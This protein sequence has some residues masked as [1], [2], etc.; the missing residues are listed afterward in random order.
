L[1]SVSTIVGHDGAITGRVAVLRDITALKELDNIKT[2]FLRMVSHDLRSPLTY[3]RGYLS[4][5]PLTGE[6][7]DRQT[8][9]LQKISNGID[10]I[11]D[12]TERL[13]YLSRLQFGD[14]AQLE[15]TMVDVE[16]L[17]KQVAVEQE[18]A[19]RQRSVSLKLDV[20]N[21]MT[22]LAADEMMYRQAISNLLSNALKY[23]PEGG[24]VIVRASRAGSDGGGTITVSVTDT[25]IGI[26]DE[27][28]SRLFEAFYRV[29]QR[30]G[31]PQR[32][33]GSGLGLALVKAIAN[34][35]GGTVGVHSVFGEG[36][37]FQ[38]TL[39][40]RKADEI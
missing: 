2:V 27:D 22:L 26:R 35:H 33:R 7:N 40:V 36:S 24:E 9:S 18:S 30:E 31:E 16:S 3:M 8:E 21:K 32:P 38:I 28:Q 15:F 5:L 1:A 12:L 29:P 37:T 23:T 10:S 20:E 39:P 19:I 13:L 4:M 17:I 14:E 11:S 25:G 34:A 6:L